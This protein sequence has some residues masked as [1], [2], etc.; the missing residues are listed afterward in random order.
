MPGNIEISSFTVNH[1][2]ISHA[3]VTES[4]ISQVFDPTSMNTDPPFINFNSIW[5]TGA[6]NSVI[7]QNVVDRCGLRPT[8]MVNVTHAGGSSHCETYL[9]S[10]M[11]KHNVRIPQIKVTKAS[12]SSDTDILIGMDII[13]LGDFVITNM[14]GKTIFSFR[15]P[16]IECIDFTKQKPSANE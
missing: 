6:T 4:G 15:T 13:T 1:N 9:V 11:L 8:G 10:I 2:I 7:S 5:D 16:S 14:N 12:L 3:L